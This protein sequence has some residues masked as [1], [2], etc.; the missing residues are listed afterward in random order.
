MVV[1]RRQRAPLF[2]RLFSTKLGTA[3]VLLA[4]SDIDQVLP[5]DNRKHAPKMQGQRSHYITYGS[6]CN[7]ILPL[8]PRIKFKTLCK[9]TDHVEAGTDAL[10]SAERV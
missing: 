2:A 3:A 10:V 7:L 4:D 5:Y 8:D 9:V 1:G 6:Q